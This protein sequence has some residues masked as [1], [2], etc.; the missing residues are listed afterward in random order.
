MVLLIPLGKM[1][2][3]V[4]DGMEQRNITR[5]DVDI[6]KPI[7]V[8]LI[9]GVK[10]HKYDVTVENG[11]AVI[12]DNGTLPVGVYRVEMFCRDLENHPMHYVKKTVVEIIEATDEGGVYETD[13]F[14]IIAKYPVAAGHSAGIVLTEDEVQI[15]EG[16]GFHGE[17]TEDEVQLYA[18]YGNSMIDV[19]DGEVRI[20]INE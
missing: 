20:I 11:F 6:T 10:R 14:G 18:E 15:H 16:V 19:T 7:R 5:L 2:V 3:T 1:T 8:E 13:E 9:A 17:V 4:M 12:N